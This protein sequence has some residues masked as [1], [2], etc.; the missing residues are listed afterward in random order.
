[1]AQKQKESTRNAAC[2]I[3]LNEEENNILDKIC[4]NTDSTKSDVMRSALVAYYKEMERYF[5]DR[6][7]TS[8]TTSD[9]LDKAEAH[10][11]LNGYDFSI[12]VQ[13]L[14]VSENGYVIDTGNWE[15]VN[16]EVA[17]RLIEKIKR[18]PILWKHFFM[19]A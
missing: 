19:V 3:R 14:L 12:L 2:K 15:N 5:T 6:A 7:T 8:T 18:H 1:M 13:N 17:L 9:I 10:G 4:K 16:A 11:Y